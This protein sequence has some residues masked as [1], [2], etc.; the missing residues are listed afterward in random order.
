MA[1]SVSVEQSAAGRA[2]EH[3]LKALDPRKPSARIDRFLVAAKDVRRLTTSEG[4]A[5]RECQRNYASMLDASVALAHAKA[6]R[7]QAKAALS[8]EELADV[9][10]HELLFLRPY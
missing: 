9:L 6:E 8:K 7:E 1:T 2:L 5:M 3:I 4:R 10:R